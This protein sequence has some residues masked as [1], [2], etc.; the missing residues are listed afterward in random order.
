M[1]FASNSPKSTKF[2]ENYINSQPMKRTIIS[3]LILFVAF[4]STNAQ[5]IYSVSSSYQADIK[6]Y[7]VNT[8]YNADLIVYK[9]DAEYKA[10]AS[11]NKGKWF[12]VNSSYNADKKVYFTDYQYNADL[13]I[14]F[15]DKEYKAG[16]KNKALQHLLY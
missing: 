15:T 6:V 10:K 1:I 13:K 3:I 5:K 4:I 8:E 2:A 9:V 16:W 12:F 11:E 14:Y 7:V